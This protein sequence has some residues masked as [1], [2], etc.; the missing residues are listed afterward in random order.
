MSDTECSGGSRSN[1]QKSMRFSAWQSQI[2][3]LKNPWFALRATKEKT[4]PEGGN[5]RN[6]PNLERFFELARTYFTA[7]EPKTLP[8]WQSIDNLW[9]K[10]RAERERG[11]QKRK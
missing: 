2:S 8:L 4:A 10:P 9:N 7:G 6:F 11:K 3:P 1:K 5:F